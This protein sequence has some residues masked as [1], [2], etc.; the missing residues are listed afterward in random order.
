[1]PNSLDHE[2]TSSQ[3]R[4]T[5]VA[6]QVTF[7]VFEGCVMRMPDLSK[8]LPS[9][10][11]KQETTKI[12][13]SKYCSS[14]TT[15]TMATHSFILSPAAQSQSHLMQLPAEL[16]LS[17]LRHLLQT[18]RPLTS[19]ID[20][21]LDQAQSE[22]YT[23]VSNLELSSQLLRSCQQLYR[24][25][26]PILYHENTLA[27]VCD[28]TETLHVLGHDIEIADYS[29]THAEHITDLTSL[30]TFTLLGPNGFHL[31]KQYEL[32]LAQA[33]LLQQFQTFDVTLGHS[34]RVDIYNAVRMLRNLVAAKHVRVRLPLMY[35]IREP[36][37]GV[38]KLWR[39]RSI[40]F[41]NVPE[42]SADEIATVIMGPSTPVDLELYT[43][44]FHRALKSYFPGW[45]D[46][47]L[48]AESPIY[49]TFPAEAKALWTASD[50]C[51]EVK[52]AKAMRTIIN[53]VLSANEKRCQAQ[54]E[55]VIAERNNQIAKINMEAE[56]SIRKAIDQLEVD[57]K[58][59]NALFR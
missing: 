56:Q 47:S 53:N 27:I 4:S 32:F 1:M 29:W 3:A 6:L 59:F 36:V 17:V 23:R 15:D 12:Q 19:D 49:D 41:M 18:D 51:D 35:L 11:F 7:T 9:R 26:R 34:N 20:V 10:L 38:F 42:G 48:Q 43:L 46:G 31:K 45:L 2:R 40:A 22:T 16:R 33:F 25:A 50:T 44:R 30:A 54:V 24:E 14:W 57:A 28:H 39:C 52:H 5:W 37:L 8:V 58:T 13:D 55:S 21:S